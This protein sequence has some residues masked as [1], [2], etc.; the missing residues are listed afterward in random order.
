M[1]VHLEALAASH[2][3][4][5][6][7]LSVALVRFRA[8]A[9]EKA[10]RRRIERADLAARLIRASD[11]LSV[12]DERTLA[13]A[14]P[15]T[16]ESGAQ[17]AMQRIRSVWTHAALGAEDKIPDHECVVI[18][19]APGESGAAMLARARRSDPH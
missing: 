4:G 12:L 2:H 1:K 18:E 17:A 5:G 8:S 16:D 6:R 11:C 14:F 15:C 3:E 19:L 7:A 10:A 13:L 9:E